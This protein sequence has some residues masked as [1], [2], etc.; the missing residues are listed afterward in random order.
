MWIVFASNCIDVHCRTG[1]LEKAKQLIKAVD[2]VHCRTG[3][4]ESQRRKGSITSVVH[5]RT[6]SLE[7]HALPRRSR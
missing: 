7:N 2:A 5:C 3:S 6:G 1:S 4:L